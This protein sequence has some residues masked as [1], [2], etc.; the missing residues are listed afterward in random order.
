MSTAIPS[1]VGT[2]QPSG[3]SITSPA[4]AFA[5]AQLQ[6]HHLQAQIQ[7]QHLQAQTLFRQKQLMAHKQQLFQ[8]PQQLL[9]Q[10]Q[11]Q[12]LLHQQQLLQQQQLM[13][14]KMP[15]NRLTTSHPVTP[16]ISQQASPAPSKVLGA[17][18]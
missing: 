10:Q 16:I 13:Q 12:H 9:Q 1:T 6:Q 11:Q 7:Q 17:P 4:Q 18:R 5:Q 3:M 14:Q 8:Q 2:P 15:G